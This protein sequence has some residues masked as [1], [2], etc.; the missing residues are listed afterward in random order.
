MGS[1]ME[2]SL[3]AS[4]KARP[5]SSARDAVLVPSEPVPAGTRVVSGIDWD[6]HNGKLSIDDLVSAMSTTG[7]QATAVA[8]AVRIIREMVF[9]A[10]LMEDGT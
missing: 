2:E 1:Q 5:V 7:F 10:S 6:S 3:R 9:T 4:G 8:D